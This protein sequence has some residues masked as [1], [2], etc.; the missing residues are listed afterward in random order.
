[1]TAK[2]APRRTSSL[3]GAHLVSA[4]APAGTP[5][6]LGPTSSEPVAETSPQ[7]APARAITTTTKLT[8]Q[9]DNHS[10]NAAKNAFWASRNAGRHRTFADFLNDA[11]QRLTSDLQAELN[12]GQPFP[13][14]PTDNLP[15]GR[16]P[17]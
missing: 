4:P 2:P 7:E 13:A 1:M 6:P 16:V 10:V 8:F 15:R 5:Q 9:A 3:A 11:V 14:R 12:H 17:S